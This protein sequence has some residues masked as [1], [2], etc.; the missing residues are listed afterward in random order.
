MAHNDL[1]LE[2]LLE[3]IK[4]RLGGVEKDQKE[5]VEGLRELN[6]HLE[7]LSAQIEALGEVDAEKDPA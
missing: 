2:Q 7:S 1:T 3:E 6:G 5:I 4:E